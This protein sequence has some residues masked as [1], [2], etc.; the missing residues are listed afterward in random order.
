MLCT[1]SRWIMV[2]MRHELHGAVKV[3]LAPVSDEMLQSTPSLG[4]LVD[5]IHGELDVDRLGMVYVGFS[6]KDARQLFE[7]GVVEACART[8]G[9]MPADL[10]RGHHRALDWHLNVQMQTLAFQARVPTRRATTPTPALLVTKREFQRRVQ[11]RF[12][13]IA[14]VILVSAWMAHLMR[15]RAPRRRVV[16]WQTDPWRGPL[17]V[18]FTMNESLTQWTKVIEDIRDQSDCDSCWA[19]SAAGALEDA[20]DLNSGSSLNERQPVD[21]G[22]NCS[23]SNG[24]LMNYAFAFAAQNNVCTVGIPRGGLVGHTDVSKDNEQAMMSTV[25]AQACMRV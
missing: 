7:D 11:K 23:G 10:Q 18:P 24:G 13:L 2:I 14:S 12:V 17:I 4:Q 16:L 9:Q 21:C 1:T 3:A 19:H 22:S 25:I 8:S 5:S 6:M 20:W 15:A